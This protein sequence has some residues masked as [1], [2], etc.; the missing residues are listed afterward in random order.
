MTNP[1]SV[2]DPAAPDT[3][4]AATRERL[5]PDLRR[6]FGFITPVNIAIYLVVGAIPGVLLPLQV[7]GIDEANKAAN[8][9]LIA[10]PVAGLISD[11]TRSRFGRRAPWLIG[12]AIITGLMLTGMGFANGVTQLI[13][14]WAVV[15]VALNF[16]ISPLTALMPD[17]VPSAARGLFATLVGVGMMFGALGGQV[18]GSAFAGNIRAAYLVLPGIMI[19]AITLFVLF[20]REPSSLD[21]VNQPFNLHLF[22][23]T[24]WVSPRKH[25]DFAW[26][27]L[28]RILLFTGYFTVTGYQLYILQDYIG[29]GDDAISFVPVLGIISLV[30]ILVSTGIAGPL[31]DR[32][33]RR[34]VFVVIASLVM[35]AAMIVPLLLPT[36]IGMIAFT[37]LCGLGFGAYMAVDAALMS[38]VLPTDGTYAKDLG[39]LN[40]AATL[41]QTLGPFL[42]GAIVV[43]AGYQAL[44]PVGLVLAA[45]GALAIIPIK[46]V[47]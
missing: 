42:S 27:F 47:K 46:S 37:A 13:I 23:K 40:I 17:R 10:S 2:A 29:L 36:A 38:E 41:P 39:V 26:G 32:L 4:R 43:F 15:Q 33:R 9:A 11:R 12:G 28:G 6:L 34:K 24:F 20:V 8:L 7:Q 35:G 5:A 18:L 22:L 3:S 44:F 31:S 16:V 25:P 1:L 14:A 19:V 45:L 30:G 21:R